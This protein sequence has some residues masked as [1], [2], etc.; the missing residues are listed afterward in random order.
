MA[1]CSKCVYERTPAGQHPCNKCLEADDREGISYFAAATPSPL[2]YP[3]F[4]KPSEL[5]LVPIE[6]AGSANKLGMCCD[7]AFF[8]APSSKE[9]CVSC[10]RTDGHKDNFKLAPTSSP[11]PESALET[12]ARHPLQEA[13][14]ACIRQVTT[15]KGE[16]HGGESEPFFDQP[17]HQISK[18]TGIG[19]LMFQ[20]EKKLGEANGKPTQETFERE[21][22]GAMAYTAMAYLYS[23]KYGFN[24]DE[25]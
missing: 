5:T 14:E 24:G 4:V 1:S 13:F 7:C 21:L 2:D 23:Q 10:T 25:K 17:W 8:N 11:A 19:G 16:I 22:L 3:T 20:A 18:R 6:T 9:P 12:Q 15:G